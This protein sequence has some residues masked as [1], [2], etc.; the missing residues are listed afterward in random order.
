[1]LTTQ[2]RGKIW[3][4]GDVLRETARKAAEW[5]RGRLTEH[6]HIRQRP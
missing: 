1:M 2:L 6:I 3:G 4:S 5:E